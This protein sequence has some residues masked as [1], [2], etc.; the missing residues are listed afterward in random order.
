[1]THIYAIGLGSNRRH[2]RYGAPM[3][4]IEAA[5]A[6][7]RPIA[8]SAIFGTD[9]IGPSSRRFAN[10][11]ALIERGSISSHVCCMYHSCRLGIFGRLFMEDVEDKAER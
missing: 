11:A 8:R 3:D 9:P 5:L 7:L 6:E 1:M 4:V 10:A 2:G